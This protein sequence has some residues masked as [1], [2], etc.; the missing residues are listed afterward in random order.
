MKLVGKLIE[1][2]GFYGKIKCVDGVTYILLEKD[3]I[4]KEINVGD[5][6][7]F[8]GEHFNNLEADTDMARFVKVLRKENVNTKRN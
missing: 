6:V 2:N 8:E 1:Y 3:L 4:D 7:Y 5:N